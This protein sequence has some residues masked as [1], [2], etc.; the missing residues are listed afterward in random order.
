[1]K[2]TIAKSRSAS[3]S[4]ATR[5]KVARMI[6]AA[7][8]NPTQEINATSR[9][10]MRNG[11]SISTTASGRATRVRNAAM[12]NPSTAIPG[13]VDGNTSRP[14]VRNITICASQAIPSKKRTR[15]RLC[16]KL[17]LRIAMPA[18]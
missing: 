11:S 16:T 12:P 5:G 4:P 17:W 8:R 3:A 1:M 9:H 14:S 2:N 15:L 10:G 6:G 18:T 13:R 7:P